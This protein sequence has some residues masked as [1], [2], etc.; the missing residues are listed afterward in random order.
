MSYSIKSEKN[1]GVKTM[2]LL[3]TE[4]AVLLKSNSSKDTNTQQKPHINYVI[5]NRNTRTHTR[6]ARLPWLAR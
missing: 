5:D 4:E 6:S 3:C 2:A 1:A